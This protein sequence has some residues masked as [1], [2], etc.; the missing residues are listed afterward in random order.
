MNI[1]W[2]CHH[3]SRALFFYA[4]PNLFCGQIGI[5]SARCRIDL[6]LLMLLLRLLLLLLLDRLF[7]EFAV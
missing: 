5:A 2:R 7:F 6:L 3:A 1:G 4:R